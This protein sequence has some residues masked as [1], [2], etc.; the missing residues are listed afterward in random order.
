MFNSDF[1]VHRYDR[2]AL[3]S[4]YSMGGGVLIA[5]RSVLPST[6]LLVP[7]TESVEM[8]CVKVHCNHDINLYVCCIYIPSGSDEATY[9]RYTEA[10]VS[11]FKFICSTLDDIVL[12]L[13]DF[14]C[15]NVEWMHD[16][17][18]SVVML[19]SKFHTY[20]DRNFISNLLSN[21]LYQLNFI[22]NFQNRFLDLVFCSVKD[23][24]SLIECLNPLC[25]IDT[26]HP[27][28]EVSIRTHLPKP[29]QEANSGDIMYNFQYSNFDHLNRYL[30]SLNWS[31]E[32]STITDIDGMVEAFYNKL[33][34][35]FD[36]YVPI[37]IP[38]KTNGPPWCNRSLKKLKNKR[39]K[40]FNIY[41][42]SWKLPDYQTYSLL[43][44]QFVSAQRKAYNEYLLKTQ[45]NIKRDPSRFWSYV[46]SKKKNTGIPTS[47]SYQGLSSTDNVTSCNLFANFF[48]NVYVDENNLPT[49]E[50]ELHGDEPEI[51][52]VN[53]G[54]IQLKSEDV[55][56]ALQSL[57][58]NKGSGPDVVTPLVVKKCA[59]SLVTPLTF[60]FN[61]SLKVGVFPTRW[62]TSY[63]IPIFKSGSR[64]K[65]E[66]YR[67][68]A[69][70][71][72][73]GKLFECLVCQILTSQIRQFI[74]PK[75]HGFMKG[76]STSTNLVEFSNYA[77]VTIEDGSQLDVIYT[78]FQKAFDR[79]LHSKLLSKLNKF[80]VHSSLL[81]WISTYLFERKQC[82]KILNC[83]SRVICVRSGVPQGSHLGP[84][85]FLLFVNDVA[86]IFKH[87]KCLLF[88]DDLKLFLPI[89]STT[90]A[91]HLQQDL[92]MLINWSNVNGLYLN[93]N[94]CKC[95][96]FHRKKLPVLFDYQINFTSLSRVKE[97]RDLGVLF[98]EKLDFSSHIEC[99]IAK[100]CSLLGF[101]LRVC[102]DFDDPATLK[103]VYF[104]HVRTVLEYCCVVWYP[105]HQIY[106][107]KIESIQKRFL[108]FMFNKFG[109][110]RCIQFA[111]YD[112]KRKLLEIESL[113]ARRKNTCI[114]FMF[115]MLSGR[116]DSSP[117]MSLI[118]INVPPRSIR[119][120]SFLRANFH[121]T[122]Y[123]SF[124]P[125]SN[126]SRIFN[127][128]FDLFNFDVARNVCRNRIITRD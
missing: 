33:L 8:V 114:Y 127:E 57:R 41:K 39:S 102:W 113:A 104:A 72:T 101:V 56:A 25:K 44:K 106:I 59:C 65:V 16:P 67:G 20:V 40:A 21:D 62:K 125:I 68:I 11:F 76:R 122:Q 80:G 128:T 69:I 107:D 37:M 83:Y 85:L 87:C 48:S 22:K 82:V 50:N 75:Q 110:L 116:I 27:A 49:H 42:K 32:F 45:S 24:V 23:D 60:I 19:P 74:S 81:N 91:M 13:G 10:I 30:S 63:I 97:I 79:L 15:S 9:R 105:N 111:P 58:V 112:F 14:N 92:D 93:A 94:K 47:L 3:N 35:G 98:D 95:I 90:D 120:H 18:N 77:I 126:L 31:D 115:D 73:L 38:R 52:K 43:R 1:V 51:N 29:L 119:N 53:L 36:Q 124:E 17:D 6:K 121:R 89:R 118:D 109:Y 99:L 88:A 117:L 70:L 12:I 71:P 46:N 55:L 2:S 54:F 4:R 108:L 100:A 66:N 64:L 28:I 84:L 5:V 26:Y 7:N 96:S 123:G 61:Y 86:D 34:I 78:D 103:A